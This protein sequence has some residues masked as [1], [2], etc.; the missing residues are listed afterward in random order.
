MQS[1]VRPLV[2]ILLCLLMACAPKHN[3]WQDIDYSSVYRRSGERE[4]DSGYTPPRSGS[5]MGCVDEDLY[6]CK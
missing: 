2:P 5:I 1:T 4:N 6:N 3:E